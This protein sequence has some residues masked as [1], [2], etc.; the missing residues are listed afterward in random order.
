MI[1]SDSSLFSAYEWDESW[2]LTVVFRSNGSVR[3][4]G[5]VPPEIYQEFHNSESK[6]KYYNSFI[7]SKF[8]SVEAGKVTDEEIAEA[9][10]ETAAFVYV[11]EQKALGNTIEVTATLPPLEVPNPR[12]QMMVEGL[13]ITDDDIRAVDPSW[14]GDAKPSDES[15]G[16]ILS[17]T[18]NVGMS[19]PKANR[20]ELQTLME[21][22]TGLA[23]VQPVIRSAAEYTEVS[24]RL[25][26]K[27]SVRD[28]LFGILDPVRKALWDALQ[29]TRTQH[30]LILDPI[31]TSIANDKKALNAWNAEQQRIAAEKQRADQ[32]EAERAAAADQ[33]R[34]TE[35]LR[36]EM[37]SQHAE[38]GD[39]EMAEASLFDETIVAAPV[40]VYAPRVVVDTPK[41]EGQSFR[42]NW[43]ARVDS[44]EE[45]V[46]DVAKG[47]ESIRATGSLA[48]HAPIT[49]L[50]PNM[51][52]LNK[53][54]KAD[55]RTNLF[56]G[57]VAFNEPVLAQRKAK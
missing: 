27:V 49:M 22:S 1:K 14:K 20:T 9:V 2:T 3:A 32:L 57:V 52:A 11:D 48:G 10:A 36:L 24:E 7:K 17:K 56:P 42:K 47:I 29:V 37:A 34:R 54:A 44:L 38:A 53:R 51:P 16:E 25:K 43:G 40:P 50:D 33:Q 45:L 46:L 28:R 23:S 15:I 8:E 35:E 55:E 18:E 4:Y 12:S 30:G 31:D 21:E 6:G 5:D 13:G 41:I 26:R 39:S 19:V